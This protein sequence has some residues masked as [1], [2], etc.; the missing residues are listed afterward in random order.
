[1]PLAPRIA[2][3]L[4]AEGHDAIHLSEQGLSRLSDE[5]VFAKAMAEGR[6]IVTADLDFGAIVARTGNRNVSVIV[7]RLV[8]LQADRVLTLLRRVLVAAAAELSQGAVVLVEESR[9]RIR[10]LPLGS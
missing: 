6:V 2:H 7:L 4:R 5:H 10:R 1:M 8:N 9:F 3:Q